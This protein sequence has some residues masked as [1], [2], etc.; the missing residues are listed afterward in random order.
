MIAPV[1]EDIAAE[2]EGRLK[3]VKVNVDEN[4]ALAA[5]FQIRSIPTLYF[6]R[7]G[8]PVSK[9]IGLQSRSDLS[10]AIDALL[11]SA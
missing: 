11:A 8:R 5:Q 2:Y 7:D 9:L 4:P 6:M 3:V 1:L 10:A